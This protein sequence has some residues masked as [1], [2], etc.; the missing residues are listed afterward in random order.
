MRVLFER[1]VLHCLVCVDVCVRVVWIVL[2]V[3]RAL[4]LFGVFVLF[5][6]FVLFVA[7]FFRCVCLALIV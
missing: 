3:R 5:V 4:F 1:I 6:L 7:Y 2:F